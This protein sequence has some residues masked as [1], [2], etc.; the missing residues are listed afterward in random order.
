MRNPSEMDDL[1]LEQPDDNWV[2]GEMTQMSLA[3]ERPSTAL[4]S[5]SS[6]RNWML[7]GVGGCALLTAL[8]VLVLTNDAEP[9]QAAS[10]PAAVE[11]PAEVAPAIE[12][13]PIEPAP[14]VTE[15]PKPKEQATLAASSAAAAQPA[16]PAAIKKAPPSPSPAAQPST[17]APAAS[18]PTPPAPSKPAAPA[19]KPAA[20]AS[21]PAPAADP[22]LPAD[23]PSSGGH[24]AELPDVEGWDEA[25]AAV[26]QDEPAPEPEPEPSNGLG[27]VA[28]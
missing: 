28:S 5:D 21:K 24:A 4:R 6:H 19:S 1:K 11:Q 20:P 13:A 9:A 2:A 8:A 15:Q 16:S 7:I 26:E 18:K 10:E 27:D 25:D 12:P 22:L 17:P 14:A 3:E 23:E